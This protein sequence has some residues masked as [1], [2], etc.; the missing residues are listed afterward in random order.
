[1]CV[2]ILT[3]VGLGTR[4][5]QAVRGTKT[6]TYIPHAVLVQLLQYLM[7]HTYQCHTWKSLLSGCC[8]YHLL[9]IAVKPQLHQPRRV[10]YRR[11]FLGIVTGTECWFNLNLYWKFLEGCV[12][13]LHG[14]ILDECLERF[15]FHR[16][17]LLKSF[18]HTGRYQMVQSKLS[19]VSGLGTRLEQ[20]WTEDRW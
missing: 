8:E 4:T 18:I 3:C 16:L 1:M 2:D 9:L 12:I 19:L 20:T 13:I 14:L 11:R 15:R 7:H 6:C 17:M 10:I 5:D